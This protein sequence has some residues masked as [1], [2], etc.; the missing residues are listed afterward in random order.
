MV[1]DEARQQALG[2][3]HVQTPQRDPDA[4]HGDAVCKSKHEVGGDQ[5]GKSTRKQVVTAKPI[6]QGAGGPSGQRIDDVH[7]HQDQRDDGER[8][9]DRLRAQQQERLAAACE[10]E[11]A[12][13]AHHQPI[14]AAHP[15]QLG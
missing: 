3:S 13:N 10:G 9:P 2:E 14:G 5:Q 7:D 11:Y 4:E 1:G 15:R 12:R 6:R 8:D